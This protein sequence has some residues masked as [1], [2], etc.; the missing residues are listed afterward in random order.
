MIIHHFLGKNK[1]M[2]QLN[3]LYHPVEQPDDIPL[4][5]R[6]DA[7]GG[8]LMM[9]AALAAGLPLPIIN[10]IASVV[11]YVINKSKS[12]F[13]RF[14]S[15]QSLYSQLPTTLLNAGLV[16]WTFKIFFTENDLL[17]SNGSLFEGFASVNDVYWGYL[18][19]VAIANVLYVIF[20]LVAAFRARKGE[21]YYF[22]FF[23]K[24]AYH[25]AYIKSN[26]EGK[27]IVNKPPVS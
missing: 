12:R 11:Y 4:R 24:L 25:T 13:I 3:E 21:F 22:L 26:N 1:F 7:M 8:Y 27:S 10:L 19:V 20:S 2:T 5:D 9:F 6:E 14:H 18:S 23:G 15:L 16:Y 17:Y